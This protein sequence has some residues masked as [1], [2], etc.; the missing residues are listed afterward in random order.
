MFRAH[1]DPAL[2]RRW[3]TGPEGWVMTRCECDAQPGGR[4][5][6]DWTDAEGENGFYL[7]AEYLEV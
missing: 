1:T 5:R 7:T 3:L 4:M 6:C 2:M